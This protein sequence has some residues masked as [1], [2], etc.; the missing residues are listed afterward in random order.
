MP[1]NTF[2]QL[3]R[4]TTFGESHGGAI[5]LVIDGCPS[6]V[7]I[8]ERAIQEDLDRR[9]PGQSRLTTQRKET[10]T[11]EVLSGI[12]EGE[13]LGTPIGMMIRNKDSRSQDYDQL[14]HVYRPSHA[15]YTWE[16]KYGRRDYRGGGRS[17]ARETATRV[18]AGAVARQWLL[19]AY[20]ID[21]VAWVQQVHTVEM[22]MPESELPS[23]DRP[24]VD[25]HLVRC[26][27][28]VAAQNMAAA[29][30]AARKDG[31]SLG[32]IIRA[33]IRNCPPG[34]GEPVFN[35]L[36]ADL[37][38]AMMSINA[39]KGFEIGSGFAAPWM[40]GSEHNDPYFR[41]ER[42][43]VRTRTNRSGGVQGGISNGEII[44]F[45]VAFKPV[46]TINKAQETVNDEGQATAL[47]AKG[48]HDPCVLPR[49]TPIVEA[50]AALTLADHML[51]QRATSP[52][53]MGTAKAQD[54]RNLHQDLE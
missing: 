2:G 5:G 53:A 35:K 40:K 41:D 11:V 25:R 21:I 33:H 45:R 16:A 22:T 54:T 24:M 10:D 44:D 50:M 20:G 52:Q 6:G 17:S 46:A 9:R 3:F 23:I 49:A 4:V 12:W 42:G 43:R 13:T 28:P 1:G 27:E 7:P 47:S 48:R 8:D 30:E 29:I 37:A 31:D 15:D 36:H 38:A 19:Q 39:T 34:L 26:P 18:A 51:R 32:G 14:R